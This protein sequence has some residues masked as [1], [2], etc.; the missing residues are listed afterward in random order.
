[1][2]ST[3]EGDGGRRTGLDPRE[4]LATIDAFPYGPGESPFRIKGNGYKG[5]LEYI[6]ALAGGRKQVFEV[7]ARSDI[8]AFYEQLFL[9]SVWYDVLP[10]LA[11][12]AAVAIIHG[13]S[14]EARAASRSRHQARK[15]I[16]GVHRMLMRLAPAKIVAL[17]VSTA[18]AQYF[19]FVELDAKPSGP[20]ALQFDMRQIPQ[21]VDV[22]L[23]VVV[24]TYLEEVLRN[25]AARHPR[26]TSERAPDGSVSGVP[27]STIHYDVSWS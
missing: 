24:R 17:R 18:L 15:D 25:G 11:T 10:I 2:V 5:N 7:L 1:M 13:E 9:P 21:P 19:D 27:A 6:D 8:E 12:T 16:G 4:M 23:E 20:T 22:W 26:V 14:F 3:M